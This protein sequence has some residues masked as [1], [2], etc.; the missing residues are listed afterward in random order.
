MTP[1]GTA[2]SGIVVDVVGKVRHPGVYRLG[3]GARVDDAVRAAGGATAGADLTLVNLARKLTDGEQVAIGVRGATGAGS[4]TQQA[5]S[6]NLGGGDAGG[7]GAAGANPA[8]SLVNLNTAS[9]ADLDGLPGVGPVLA[10][11]ILEWRA[12]HGSFASVDQ[13]RLVS[14]IG[15]AK[16]ADLRPLVTIS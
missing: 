12:A 5:G 16:F 15:D 13:L 1:T 8:G 7:N 3:A 2:A 11:H 14:G 6:G 4:G 9:E 10:Q